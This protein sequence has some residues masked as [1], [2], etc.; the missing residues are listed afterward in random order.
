MD[1]GSPK[2]RRRRGT[3]GS[4]HDDHRDHEAIVHQRKCALVKQSRLLVAEIELKP[5]LRE[6][7]RTTRER[8]VSNAVHDVAILAEHHGTKRGAALGH[9]QVVGG[10]QE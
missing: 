7:R 3:A 5:R 2:L 8:R 10:K 6:R 4:P 9:A 1:V